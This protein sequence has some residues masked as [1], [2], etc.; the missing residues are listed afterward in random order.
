MGNGS[1]FTSEYYLGMPAAPSFPPLAQAFPGAPK[2]LSDSHLSA[3]MGKNSC[4]HCCLGSQLQVAWFK[5]RHSASS[6]LCPL[7][8]ASSHVT[9][10]QIPGQIGSMEQSQLPLHAMFCL[11]DMSWLKSVMLFLLSFL[12]LLLEG[13][14][15]VRVRADWQKEGTGCHDLEGSWVTPFEPSLQNYSTPQF[16]AAFS[17]PDSKSNSAPW[18][19]EGTKT[20]QP[21]TECR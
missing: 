17:S 6:L 7:P 16:T 3:W 13:L 12:K 21:Q 1:R 4:R 8:S 9:S 18:D 5:F 10:T 2:S 19:R 20:L 15:M 11:P 14:A